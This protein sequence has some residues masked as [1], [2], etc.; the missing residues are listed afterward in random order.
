MNTSQ[1]SL[2]ATQ[3]NSDAP[4]TRP[5]R[6]FRSAAPTRVEDPGLPAIEDVAA[7]SGHTLL[8]R[9]PAPQGRRSLF[10]L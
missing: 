7:Q 1:G 2:P 10:R 9:P 4:D 6:I 8:S 3:S 5:V